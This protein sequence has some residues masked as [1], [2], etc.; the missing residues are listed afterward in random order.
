MTPHG[1][2]YGVEGPPPEA[3][4]GH[5]EVPPLRHEGEGAE[6]H[7]Q[8]HEDGVGHHG[9]PGGG[10]GGA[11][12]GGGGVVGLAAPQVPPPGLT[13]G[14]HLGEGEGRRGRRGRR[15]GAGGG[16]YEGR[17]RGRGWGGQLS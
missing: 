7:V 8:D 10:V 12:G 3:G 17:R 1:G 11:G 5:P 9:E 6:V 16:G 2:D 15:R 13:R 14:A 4:V